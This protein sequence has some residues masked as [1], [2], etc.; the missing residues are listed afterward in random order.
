[1][2]AIYISCICLL[3][4]LCIFLTHKLYKFSILI[5]NVEKAIEE[6]LDILDERYSKINEIAQK[7][8]FFDSVEIRQTIA[9]IKASHDAILIIANKL[10]Y[11]SGLTSEIKKED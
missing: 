2:E 3:L 1:M 4:V 9:E 8:V 6:S 10:T 7:P 5:L 11:E